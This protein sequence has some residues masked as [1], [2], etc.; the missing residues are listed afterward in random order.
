MARCVV[1]LHAGGYNGEA[2]ERDVRGKVV[3]LDLAHANCAA[4]AR[5][6]VHVLGVV[7]KIGILANELL[8]RLEVN[9]V[10]LVEPNER[11]KEAEINPAEALAVAGEVALLGEELLH[12]VESIEQSS[13]RVLV[14][15]L[16]L[17]EAAPVHAVVNVIV[18]DV[19]VQPRTV[20]LQISRVEVDR[21]VLRKVVERGIEDTKDVGGLV[22]HDLLLELVPQ[23]RG[24]VLPSSVLHM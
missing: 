11:H 24:A 20:L 15:S 19:V 16:R 5:D 14:R 23:N 1:D 9:D 8:V 10:N 12:L 7:E 18:D 21:G 6:L 2:V 3:R 17:G 22:G 13:D 4:D